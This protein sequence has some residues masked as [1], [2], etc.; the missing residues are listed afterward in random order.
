MGRVAL[1]QRHADCEFKSSW[2]CGFCGERKA[3]LYYIVSPHLIHQSVVS[4]YE[5]V[6]LSHSTADN[7]NK[8]LPIT[9]VFFSL[10]LKPNCGIFRNGGVPCKDTLQFGFIGSFLMIR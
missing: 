2:S 9:A 5:A 7:K 8:G 10:D 4:T 1:R 6:G 3:S